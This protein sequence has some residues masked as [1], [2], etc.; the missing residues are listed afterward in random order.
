MLV[1]GYLWLTQKQGGTSD[2]RCGIVIG[3]L[4]YLMQVP[5]SS[6]ATYS[7]VKN[8]PTIEFVMLPVVYL[9]K[10]SK[11]TPVLSCSSAG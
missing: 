6:I 2:T 1:L 3:I 7:R 8:F 10:L 9:L 11:L 5:V 4:G